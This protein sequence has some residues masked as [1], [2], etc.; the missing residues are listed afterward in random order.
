MAKCKEEVVF[1]VFL[2]LH[3]DT[4]GGVVTPCTTQHRR[5]L[6]DHEATVLRRLLPETDDELA[7]CVFVDLRR[8]KG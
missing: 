7:G 5:R 6:V 4:E 2:T 3:R 8:Q 1:C